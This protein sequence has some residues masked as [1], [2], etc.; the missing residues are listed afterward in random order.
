MKYYRNTIINAPESNI[1]ES[2]IKEFTVF[3]ENS[4]ILNNALNNKYINDYYNNI[5]DFIY[6]SNINKYIK[7]TEIHPITSVDEFNLYSKISNIPLTKKYFYKLNSIINDITTTENYYSI[8][9]TLDLYDL[10][11][12]DILFNSF[13]TNEYLDNTSYIN[14]LNINTSN[15][16]IDILFKKI[17]FTDYTD[18]T[19]Y[20]TTEFAI[21]FINH[22]NCILF[23]DYI[24]Y[25]NLNNIINELTFIVDRKCNNSFTIKMDNNF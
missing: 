13:L 21:D 18:F 2:N 12:N 11:Y 16:I 14:S 10:L 22:L 24:I 25:N 9:I 19:N 3:Y 5:T 8:K 4:N 20:L 17:Q 6:L 1:Y 7:F 23:D 15:Y